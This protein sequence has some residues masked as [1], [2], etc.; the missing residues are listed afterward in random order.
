MDRAEEAPVT[1]TAC[2]QESRPVGARHRTPSSAQE[3]VQ[4]ALVVMQMQGCYVKEEFTVWCGKHPGTL[5]RSLSH[6]NLPCRCKTAIASDDT[7]PGNRVIGFV[8]TQRYPLMRKAGTTTDVI[9]VGEVQVAS[10]LCAIWRMATSW[11]GYEDVTENCRLSFSQRSD[12]K[13]CTSRT[14]RKILSSA[15]A[16]MDERCW[17]E[18]FHF[19]AGS[20]GTFL[21]KKKSHKWWYITKNDEG[22]Q[23]SFN[24]VI[25]MA[26]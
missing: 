5:S 17:K 14:A 20:Y 13:S 15:C 16:W 23:Q 12:F 7:T 24:M 3:A 19:G 11:E 2:H 26:A 8:R 4:Q 22:K 18:T 21:S 25:L 6:E 9:A 1:N 10:G